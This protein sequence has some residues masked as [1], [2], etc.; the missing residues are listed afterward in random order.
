MAPDPHRNRGY[1]VRDGAPIQWPGGRRGADPRQA[2]PVRQGT[3]GR[4]A[5]R[6]PAGHAGPLAGRS[7]RRRRRRAAGVRRLRRRRRR[8]L[9]RRRRRRGALEPGPRAERRRRRRAGRR[10]P[11][12]ASTTSSSPTATCPWPTTSTG[13]PQPGTVTLVPDRHRDG[14]NVLALPIDADV[15]ASYG[16]G[17]FRRHLELAMATGTRVRVVADVRAWRSTSTTPPT[18]ATR[19]PSR[20]CRHGCERPWPA[21]AERRRA[22]P[23]DLAV[24]AVGARHRRPPRR[25]RVRRRR[26]AGQVGGR[27]LHRPPPRLH[28]R[29]QGHVGRRRRPRRRSSPAASTS[30]AKRPAAWPATDAGEVVFLGRVD[31]DLTAD[32]DTRRAPSPGSIR[33]LRPDVVLG[34]DP[35]KRYRLHPDHRNA[36]LL[37]CDAI[38]AARDPHFFPEHGIAHHR[39]DGAAAVGGRRARPRRG[40]RPT[41][42]T[43]SWPRSRPTR[44]SSSRRC[45]PPTASA[46]E[47]FRT[48]IRSP[49][50]RARRAPR[51]RRR[52]GLPPHPR[53]LT[54]VAT[55]GPSGARELAGLA[56]VAG[57]AGE[58]LGDVEPLVGG[59]RL[60]PSRSTSSRWRRW[61]T[62]RQKSSAGPRDP[63]RSAS[64]GPHVHVSPEGASSSTRIS[65]VGHRRGRWRRS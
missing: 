20:S 17:S 38:V 60:R 50:G 5:H 41:T 35:W 58:R 23:R 33:T 3:S 63:C 10:S 53:P 59:R 49:A 36:G 46:L 25:R 8:V 14:T 37:V 19:W 26:H 54:A 34:H 47:P 40:R 45:T 43:P 24:P 64:S 56:A 11:A 39:P 30:S 27:G 22:G 65:A 44:A 9:G 52:R 57:R 31:G 2:V 51:A 42:S 55:A 6:R 29:L 62:S 48:R 21:G 16:G 1:E 28:R 4:H 12:R 13:S 15:P 61:V 18:S 7:G 32:R